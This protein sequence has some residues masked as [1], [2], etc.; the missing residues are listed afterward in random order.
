MITVVL[1]TLGITCHAKEISWNSLAIDGRL[2][3]AACGRSVRFDR[4]TLLGGVF[5]IHDD[6]SGIFQDGFE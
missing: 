3:T 4:A 5:T 6:Q 1:L 2:A